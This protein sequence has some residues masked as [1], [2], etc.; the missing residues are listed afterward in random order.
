MWVVQNFSGIEFHTYIVDWVMTIKRRIQTQVRF[1][2]FFTRKNKNKR[3]QVSFV[4][5]KNILNLTKLT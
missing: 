1:S 4:K 2:E 5:Y 3:G